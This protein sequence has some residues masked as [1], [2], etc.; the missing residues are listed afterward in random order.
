MHPDAQLPTRNHGNRPMSAQEVKWVDEENKRFEQD[1]PE[2]FAAGYRVGLPQEFDDKGELWFR[3]IPTG[4]ITG[5]GDTGYDLF[6]VEDVTIPAGSSEVVPTGIDVAYVSPGYWFKIEARSGLGFKYSVAPHPG[7]I[8]NGYTGN[9]G[10]KLYNFSKEDYFVKKGDRI[11]Q[12]VFYPVVE[13]NISWADE[14]NITQR[15]NSGFGDSG[16]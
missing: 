12:I 15:G 3:C 10:I 6:A 9:L 14:K 5:T 7:I 8:D 2:Q 11:A 16:K 1:R 13:V 4:N